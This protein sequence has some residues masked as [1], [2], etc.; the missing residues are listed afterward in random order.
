MCNVGTRLK[1]TTTFRHQA[2]GVTERLNQTIKN[3]L[4]TFSNGPSTDW[5]SYL[6]MAVFAYNSRFQLSISMTPFEADL[7]YLPSTLATIMSP[8]Q[9]SGAERQRQA[10]GKT[11][12]KLQSDQ[13]NCRMRKYYDANRPLQ[14][15]EV[16]EE[17]LL[18]TGNLAKYH[19]GITKQKLDAR[20]I[21]P[22]AI[23]YRFGHDYYVIK[24]PKGV[25]FHPVFHIS[26]LKPC[27]RSD[28]REQ[29]NI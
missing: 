1:L 17:V 13:G 10:F 26:Y 28:D 16:A 21:G 9:S 3:Y 6:A 2:N 22:Y 14:I 12:L 25:K 4:R 23:V 29:K 15:F 5:H 11:F 18:S 27:V 19:A 8:P 7:G 24:L 20:W